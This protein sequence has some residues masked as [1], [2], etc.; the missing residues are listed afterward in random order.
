[1]NDLS[2]I[3]DAVMRQATLATPRR[4]MPTWSQEEIDYLHQ[5]AGSLDDEQIAA[6]LGRTPNAV[7]IFRVRQ[8]LKTIT[9]AGGAW[10]TA[11]KVAAMFQVTV[12]KITYWCRVGLMP[13]R[14]KVHEPSGREY[15]LVER[16]ALKRWCVNPRHWVYFDWRTLTDPRIRRLC[17]LRAERWG[18]EW[19]D[20]TRVAKY[21]GVDVQDVKRLVARGEIKSYRPEYSIGGRDFGNTW[22]YRFILKSEATRADLVFVRGRGRWGRSKNFSPAFD[23]FLLRAR[24]EIGLEFQVIARMMKAKQ[25]S[26]EYRYHRL[27]REKQPNPT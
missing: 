3:I 10:L 7:K 25:K 13:A 16:E 14:V 12:H 23:A 2:S 24:N 20:T 15:F 18:D 6:T 17:E 1:M 22:R 5:N 11:N 27:Q 26:I 19:W 21:H 8:G 9:R 4:K